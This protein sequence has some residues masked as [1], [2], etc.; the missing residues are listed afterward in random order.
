MKLRLFTTLFCSFPL[1]LLAQSSYAPLNE[2]YYHWVDRYEIKAGRI[3]PQIFTAVK[4]YKRSAIAAFVDTLS[5]QEIFES[6]TD[7]FNE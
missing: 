3:M 2:D 7:K 6:R 5:K 1:V 4:P